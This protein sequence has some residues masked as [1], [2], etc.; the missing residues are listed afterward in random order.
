[1]KLPKLVVGFLMN[2]VALAGMGCADAGDREGP[3]EAIPEPEASELFDWPAV[4]T[5][6]ITLPPERWQYLQQHAVDEEYEPAELTFEGR[7]VGQVGL[8]FK[9]NVGTLASCFDA[10]GNQTCPKLSMKVKFDKYDP[11]LRFYGLKRL[12]LHSMAKDPSLLRE[13]LAYDLYRQMDIVAP[14]SAWAIAQVNGASLGVFS[15]VEEIDGRFTQDRWQPEGDGNLY[16]EAWPVSDDPEH[17]AEALETN[18][19]TATHEAFVDFAS[20][21]GAAQQADERRAVLEQWMDVDYLSRYMAVDDALANIDG[22]TAIYC[23]AT[24]PQACGNHNYFFYLTE[25]QTRFWLVP[26]DMDATLWPQ[27]AYD[28]IPP[29]HVV[30][31][32]CDTRYGLGDDSVTLAAPGCDPLFNGL[33]YDLTR[34]DAALEEVLTG[35]FS[36]EAAQLAIDQHAAFIASSVASDPLGPSMENWQAAVETLKQ[37]V[38]K[39]HTRAQVRRRGLTSADVALSLDRANDFEA[40]STEQLDLLQVLS[41][42][43][44]TTSMGL[45]TEQPLEG[46]QTLRLSFDYRN[47]LAKPWGQWIYF[48]LPIQGQPVDI[49]ALSGIRLTVRTDSPRTLRVD[50]DSQR[51]K[52]ADE[53]IK[54]GW[55]VAATSTATTV[56]LHFADAAV[57]PWAEPVGDEPANIFAAISGLAF[58]PYCSGRNDDGMLSDDASDPGYLEVDAI[59]FF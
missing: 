27:N 42:A 13:K 10:N 49:S 35:A 24:D 38:A 36:V 14:R 58:H 32:A 44:T 34:Y 54:L 1:M 4:P 40:L 19:D 52:A 50:L 2:I 45:S 8:R 22:A 39:L 53:G 55:D 57:P 59:E 3:S 30:P 18:E 41:N 33:A 25:D 29:W 9:G 23:S 28:H 37:N 5:F 12:N 46:A 48:P 51:Y 17:Y 15:M 43:R 31:E 47:D 11:E 26:W 20:E 7:S 16:K 56:E 6:Q 21:L